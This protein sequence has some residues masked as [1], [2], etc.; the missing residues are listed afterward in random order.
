MWGEEGN[1][2]QSLRVQQRQQYADDLRRQIQEKQ[3]NRRDIQNSNFPRDPSNQ[4]TQAQEFQLIRPPQNGRNDSTPRRFPNS[5]FNNPALAPLSSIPPLTVNVQHPPQNTTTNF[6]PIHTRHAPLRNINPDTNT[7]PERVNNLENTVYGIRDDLNFKAQKAADLNENIFPSLNRQISDLR[8]QIERASSQIIP[9]QI[10]PIKN[11]VNENKNI[12]ENTMQ[13]HRDILQ[14]LHSSYSEI[15]NKVSVFIPSFNDFQEFSKSSFV[16]LRGE[17]H[18]NRAAQ[19]ASNGKLNSLIFRHQNIFTN[20]AS[21]NEELNNIDRTISSHFNCLQDNSNKTITSVLNQLAGEIQ[22]ESQNRQRI[23]TTLQSQA[24]QVNE[25][26]RNAIQSLMQNVN[27]LNF[28]DLLNQISTQI[29]SSINSTQSETDYSVT[30][31][32][33]RLDTLVTDCED[34]FGSIQHET[35]STIE[36]I[37]A[38]HIGSMEAIWNALDVESRQRQKNASEI[39]SKYSNFTEL[40]EN[41]ERLQMENC[42]NIFSEAISSASQI[43]SEITNPLYRNV[44]SSYVILNNYDETEARIT[45]LEKAIAEVNNQVSVKIAS[46][47]KV[48]DQQAQEFDSTR[49]KIEAEFDDLEKHLSYVE[50][51]EKKP[52]SPVSAPAQAARRIEIQE[53]EK[54]TLTGFEQKISSTEEQLSVIFQQ[55][56]TLSNTAQSHTKTKN[57]TTL[58]GRTQGSDLIESLA[59]GDKT[60]NKAD[61]EQADAIVE[62]EEEVQNEEEEEEED[63]KDY[64]KLNSNPALEFTQKIYFTPPADFVPE[65][66]EKEETY[67]KRRPP[68]VSFSP[69]IFK[70]DKSKPQSPR[71]D[72]SNISGNS[73][74]VFDSEVLSAEPDSL[75]YFQTDDVSRFLN[76]ENSLEKNPDGADSHMQEQVEKLISSTIND[77]QNTSNLPENKEEPTEQNNITQ[78]INLNE[79]IN[80]NIPEQ[81]IV[82]NNFDIKFNPDDFKIDITQPA[83]GSSR[84]SPRSSQLRQVSKTL[85]DD[86]ELN[87][88]PDPNIV[89]NSFAPHPIESLDMNEL[90]AIS[91]LGGDNPETNEDKNNRSSRSARS[92][93]SPKNSRRSH[94]QLGERKEQALRSSPRFSKTSFYA[95]TEGTESENTSPKTQNSNNI[96]PKAAKRAMSQ[97]G[98]PFNHNDL[99]ETIENSHKFAQTTGRNTLDDGDDV[100]E[101]EDSSDANNKDS[102]SLSTTGLMQ[103]SQI[104]DFDVDLHEEDEDDESDGS[105]E[106]ED[107]F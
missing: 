87:S 77:N 107:P 45:K 24:A 72:I 39:M 64:A 21:Q 95:D 92:T 67:P 81:Q 47:N 51:S 76:S 44:H 83:Q 74:Q 36:A 102:S 91:I 9:Q 12:M 69:D 100:E 97:T 90:N 96:T 101:G 53:A 71:N 1:R 16:Q 17:S 37:K 15:N 4:E 25:R 58:E 3:T 41:E 61:D 105:E 70:N 75:P 8:T 33:N 73:S 52:V 32:S 38:N 6:P 14:S 56:L 29:A 30:E 68:V 78:E 48:F 2:L 82:G 13:N 22:V 35:I 54:A 93:G 43:V 103:N 42:G 19:E 7:F 49:K 99:S 59:K 28:S 60:I 104:I 84:S 106:E 40:I 5:N 89:T 31:I 79:A 46:L 66:E 26:V 34:S 18:R 27:Q 20:L 57:I 50:L 55:L 10:Q 86:L 94:S 85:K 63:K 23:L 62:E 80:K 98:G 88:N 11:D 65:K